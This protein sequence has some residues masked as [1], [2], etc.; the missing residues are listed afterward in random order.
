MQKEFKKLEGKDVYLIGIGNNLRYYKDPRKAK[1]VKV[2]RVNVVV[3]FEG[4][5]MDTTLRISDISSKLSLSD[6]P[7]SGWLVFPTLS[8]LENHKRKYYLADKISEELRYC[9]S[10]RNKY[11][12]ETLEKI[13][14]LI[15]IH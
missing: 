13:A 11:D 2:A 4:R 8:D 7:N 14:D 12:L 3:L 6:G 5:R 15:N 9:S 1:L 10:I